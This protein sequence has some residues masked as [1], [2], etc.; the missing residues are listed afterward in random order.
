MALRPEIHSPKSGQKRHGRGFTL[1][2]LKDAGIS[3]SD[4]RWMAIP[5]D[6]RRSTHYSE[7]I[8]ILKEYFER[9]RKLSEESKPVKPKERPVEREAPKPTPVPVETDLTELPQITKKIVETLVAAGVTS[10]HSL[11][12]TSPRR[13][14]RLTDIKRGR[15]EKLVDSAKRHIRDESRAIR[16]EKAQKPKITELKH[17]PDISRDDI[18]K[19]KDLGVTTLDELESENTRDLSLLTGIAESRIKEWIKIIRKLSKG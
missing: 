10:I 1:K 2:E 15:A 4:A 16:E 18:R 19:L 3:L 14:A 13:I 8:T 9:I 5:I 17:L 6:R 7:N 11:S 12:T